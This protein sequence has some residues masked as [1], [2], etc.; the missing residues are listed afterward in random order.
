MPRPSE[1]LKL[2]LN[3]SRRG[4]RRAAPSCHFRFLTCHPER[5]AVGG[6]DGGGAQSKEPVE[7][8]VTLLSGAGHFQTH[9]R[10]NHFDV[11]SI[12]TGSFDFATRQLPPFHLPLRSAQD[13]D[14]LHRQT[15]K[16][17][18]KWRSAAFRHFRK[19]F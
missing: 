16:G 14:W 2:A 7:R 5:S 10:N 6:A 9:L 19:R 18:P 12:S 8:Q 4:E 3:S 1:V 13:D 11:A 15:A 17:E